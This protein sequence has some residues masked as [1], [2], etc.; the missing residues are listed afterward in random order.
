MTLPQQR[1]R[2]GGLMCQRNLR[3]HQ[4]VKYNFQAKAWTTR[5]PNC[6][7][8]T[9]AYPDMELR[10]GAHVPGAGQDITSQHTCVELLNGQ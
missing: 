10:T 6:T 7:K 3:R 1:Q 8:A 2:A 9:S 5:S 4:S